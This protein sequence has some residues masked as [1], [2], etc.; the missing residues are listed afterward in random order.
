MV[1]TGRVRKL[2]LTAHILASV[3][4]LGAVGCILG[5]AVAG[6]AHDDDET[7][8][9]V[10]LAMDLAAWTVLVP[11]AI[12]SLVTGLVQ[13]LGTSWGLLRHYWV[14][15]KLW[16]TVIATIVLLLYTATLDH[17]AG[18][19]EGNASTAE[20]E[21]PTVVVHAALALILLVGATVL[22][23]FKP[24]GLTKRGRAKSRSA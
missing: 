8:R 15:V 21:G 23:V 18:V 20:L 13:S 10:Y 16:I 22:A 14:V 6:I 11:M 2:A 4:W 3:G 5:L 17:L 7:A 1:L 24:A 12:A 19:A 9:A